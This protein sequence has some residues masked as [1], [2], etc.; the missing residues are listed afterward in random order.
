MGSPAAAG[1]P[2]KPHDPLTA[3][4]KPISTPLKLDGFLLR[5]KPILRTVKKIRA[6]AKNGIWTFV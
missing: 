3:T 4:R 6:V 2:S 5:N 1:N